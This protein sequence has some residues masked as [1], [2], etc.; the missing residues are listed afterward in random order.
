VSE[1]GLFMVSLVVPSMDEGIAHFTN[2]WGFSIANDTHH[3]SGHRWVEITT[4]G[5]AR[6]RLVEAASDAERSVIGRQAGDRIAF[7]LRVKDFDA[8]VAKWRANGVMV[9]ESERHE[10]YGRIIVMRDTFGNR[11]DVRESEEL[12]GA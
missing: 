10:A 7:F 11:W 1:T 12:A 9:S 5:G 8:Q 3:A 4:G 2:D 6:L